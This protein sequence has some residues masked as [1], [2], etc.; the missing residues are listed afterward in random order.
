[1]GQFFNKVL[2]LLNINR[3]RDLP[4]FLVSLALAFC[5][6]FIYKILPTYSNDVEVSVKAECNIEGHSA[7]SSENTKVSATC[8]S[9]GY[10][11][12][13]RK[14]FSRKRPVKV[15]FSK[16]HPTRDEEFFYLTASEMGE[17]SQQIFGDNNVVESFAR[18]TFFFKFPT[19]ICRKLPV[20]P[21]LDLEFKP[22]YMM[23][24]EMTLSPDSITVYGDASVLNA[25]DCVQ[26][27]ARKLS[28]IS[29]SI[30]GDVKLEK[31][32]GVRFSEKSVEYSAAV[33]RYVEL[34]KKFSVSARNV[35]IGQRL[36]L[37][38]SDVEVTFK[39]RFPIGHPIDSVS[40]YVDYNDFLSARSG[41]CFVH[42]DGL[43]NNVISW[44]A[45]PDV[46]EC[47]SDDR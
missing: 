14:V 2:T 42:A 23:L 22:Q 9:H 33:V 35:P 7:E 4:V 41:K 25:L 3:G 15:T 32:D 47:V 30:K 5:I 46:V 17:Y 1:M 29:S 45:S 18:D 20:R 31:P 39:C 44:S 21:V 34:V 8:T 27:R 40:L 28:G 19:E 36:M 26:T 43:T 38:P 24:G 10:T 16:L 6:W 13:R 12:I 11:I 37:N